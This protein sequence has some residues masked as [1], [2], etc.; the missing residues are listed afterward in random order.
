MPPRRAFASVLEQLP[1]LRIGRRAEV[2]SGVESRVVLHDDRGERHAPWSG[3][4]VGV[5]EQ[6]C[7]A[8]R[9]LGRAIASLAVTAT[10]PGM[11][12]ATATISSLVIESPAK[13]LGFRKFVPWRA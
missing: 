12:V 11:P 2:G 3:I 10:T 4:V 8:P 1:E 5:E 9:D 13:T 7:V 6:E